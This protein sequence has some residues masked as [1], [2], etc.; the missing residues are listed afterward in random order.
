MTEPTF[1]MTFI[2]D[3]SDPRPASPSDLSVVGLV[4]DSEDADA[5]V[6]PLDVAVSFN[7]SD[8]AYLGKAGTGPLYRALVKLNAQLADLQIAARVAAVRVAKG[9]DADATITNIVGEAS[10]GKGWYAMLQAGQR[11][12]VIPRLLASPGYP[13][14]FT[15]NA[16]Q[17]AQANPICALLPTI[18]SALLAH[19]YVGGPGTTKQDALDW[20]ETI[21]SRR[22]VLADN[23][24]LVASTDADGDPVTLEEDGIMVAIGQ[25]V[26]ADF[27]AGGVPM[28]A[29]A[30]RPAKGIVGLKRYDSFS[31]TDGATDGQI[32]LANQIGVT[33]RGELGLETA[34]AD[35]GF[36]VIVT[37]T[38]SD[39]PLWRMVNVSRVRDYEHLALLISTR[40]RLGRTNI[41]KHGVQAVLNDHITLLAD[42]EQK[43][44]ILPGWKVGFEADKNNPEN[45]RLGRIRTFY[46]AEEPPTLKH[47]T[48]DSRRDRESLNVLIEDL[49]TQTDRLLGFAT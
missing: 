47:V 19:A 38:A 25:Q 12:G 30:N 24:D 10:S 46:K 7:S 41:T 33:Q 32:L 18:T 11:L 34:V 35:S 43:G 45:L 2:Q 22:M 26:A 39:D 44:A 17:V 48:I 15:R 5:T 31:T 40:R 20:R 3:N 8:P 37:D 23:W 49:V 36:I 9:A 6:F 27:E 1:G 14:K 13:G 16:S 4:L 42:L 21:N 29:P 28:Y